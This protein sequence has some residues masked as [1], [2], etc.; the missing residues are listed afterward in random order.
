MPHQLRA[1]LANSIGIKMDAYDVRDSEWLH[2]FISSADYDW[3]MGD[4]RKHL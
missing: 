3:L 4:W 1:Q 2:D